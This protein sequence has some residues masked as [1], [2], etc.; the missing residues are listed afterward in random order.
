MWN[1]KLYQWENEGKYVERETYT[2][3][4]NAKRRMDS[5]LHFSFLIFNFSFS[6]K[7]SH[8]VVFEDLLLDLE[9][10]L[11]GAILYFLCTLADDA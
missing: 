1:E 11:F 7:Q 9:A 4:R 6:H 5:P 3:K 8:P 10:V 2:R